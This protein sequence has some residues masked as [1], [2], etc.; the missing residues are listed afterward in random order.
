MTISFNTVNANLRVPG[1]YPEMDNS[2]ANTLQAS[3]P[4][5]LIG[6]AL[7]TAQMTLN[8]PMIMPS[9]EMIQQLA[10]RGSQL[11]RMVQAY[12]R[13][14]AVGELFVIAVPETMGT[15]AKGDITISGTATDSG[16]V[17]LYIGNQRIL[18]AV[19]KSDTANTVA[20]AL[21]KAINDNEDLPVTATIDA[22]KIS[23]TAKHKGL[24]GND[25]PLMMN[26]Y[27]P[28]GGENTPHGLNITI[29]AMSGGAGSPDMDSVISA[30]GDL[31]F[32]FIGL[33]FSDTASL[34]KMS[35]EMNDTNGRWSPYQR[36]YGHV[37]T[38]KKATVG[39]LVAFGDTFNDPHLTI[40]GYEKATQT[41]LDELV[42]ARL[43][44]CAIFL[45]NDPARPTHTGELNGVLPAPSGKRFTL[46]EQ[47]SL[48]SHGI[49]TANVE[50]GV[51]RI[52]RDVTTYQKN[53]YGVAD[54]SYL[55]SETLYTSAYILR[56]LKSVITS[57]YGRQ[58][59][60]DDGTRFGAGQAIVTPAVIKGELCAVYRQLENEGIVENFDA[61]RQH[62]IVERNANDPNRID[63]VFPADYINQLRV[64]ALANQFRL[65]YNQGEVV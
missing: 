9:A 13:I 48:L 20:A 5:L 57:K 27:S 58:K 47:Q 23:L 2:A 38:A 24:T 10:G 65:Q 15:E 14:D 41:A 8:S 46:T 4:A 59:L 7:P 60:A 45:R 3:G 44:R 31:L 50:G 33:P 22:D 43:A 55:D 40:A 39:E 35:A 49:A 17:T 18:A 26:Y 19:K 53:S 29:T 61:F 34:Q 63:V 32:D 1:F 64:F 54:N 25:I 11:H 6:H 12:R 16:V 21:G 36:L 37:Y 28:T 42:A 51:L 62:L 30:M 56:R 52:Q